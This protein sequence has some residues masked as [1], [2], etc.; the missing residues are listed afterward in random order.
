MDGGEYI[1]T[2]SSHSP[3]ELV[4]FDTLN[5]KVFTSPGYDYENDGHGQPF[6][7][8]TWKYTGSSDTTTVSWDLVENPFAV[9]VFNVTTGL[10]LR[11]E[12]F[13]PYEGTVDYSANWL[14]KTVTLTGSGVSVGDILRVESYGIGGGDQLWVDNYSVSDLL[15][16]DS[17]DGL[18]VDI[19]VAFEDIYEA[20]IKV[21]GYR[22]TNYTFAELNETTTRVT[23]GTQDVDGNG[24]PDLE[25]K[26]DNRD[27]LAAGDY[28][29]MAVFGYDENEKST[30]P[31]YVTHDEHLVHSS[32]HPTSQIMYGNGTRKEFSLINDIQGTNAFT[33]VVEIDG[34]RLVP[35]EGIE[36]T[37]D[38]SSEGPFYLNLTNWSVTE[39]LFQ[40]VIADSDVHC[41][42]D[43]VEQKLYEDFTVSAV[44][45]STVRYVV[46][47]TAPAAGADVNIFVETSAEYRI[48]YSGVPVSPGLNSITF[49]TA[50]IAGARIMVTTDN[51]TSELDI[52]NR[53]YRGPTSTGTSIVTGFDY[54]G[55]D[56]DGEPFDKTIGT[57]VDLSN[58]DLGRSIAKPDK[59]RVTVNGL[60]KYL[61]RDWQINATDST[62]LQFISMS[63]T[64]SDVVVITLQTENE[65]P[66]NLNFAI[67]KDMRDNNAVYR[68]KTSEQTKLTQAL[69]A[70]ADTIY[71][72]DAS[73]L[74]Q[75]NLTVGTFGIVI[76]NGERITYRERDVTNNTLSGL[77][78]GTA[79]TGAAAHAAGSVAYDYSIGT[80]LDYSYNKTWYDVPTVD[81]GSSVTQGKALQNTNTVPAKFLKGENS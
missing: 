47:T 65:V 10:T 64:D 77:R 70:T 56:A 6:G 33:A 23:F 73:K 62:E 49:N 63:I 37:G 7:S 5:M 52:I 61:G 48:N 50:P 38:G 39:D 66:D 16:D 72:T 8:Y 35:A 27:P 80:Y 74:A 29:G 30:I 79:G 71:V 60:R 53:C 46:F 59:L 81:D 26:Y 13:A 2:Y 9:R 40:T 68:I 17:T 20:M 21:N 57:I 3:E 28:I 55:F 54:V 41:F 19:P 15:I 36:Y 67:F 51:N 45:A 69:S 4:P 43:G 24:T 14:N 34:R 76:I 18:Y 42:V 31:G 12:Y 75:P 32:S 44:D 1:D 58:F 22:V 11:F 25:V 78:R